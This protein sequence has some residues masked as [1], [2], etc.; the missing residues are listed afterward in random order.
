M[1]ASTALFV[2]KSTK[3]RLSEIQGASTLFEGRTDFEVSQQRR[4]KEHKPDRRP[5]ATWDYGD[6]HKTNVGAARGYLGEEV[7]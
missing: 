4:R 1:Q 3:P 5:R 7:L 6:T 2:T